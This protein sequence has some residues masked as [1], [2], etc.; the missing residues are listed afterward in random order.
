MNVIPRIGK[1]PE[2]APLDIT[3]EEFELISQTL[4]RQHGFNLDAYKD[5][6]IKRRIAIRVRATRCATVREYCDILLNRQGEVEQLLKVLT[7]HVSQFFRNP[8]T[9]DKLRQEIIPYLFTF[10][11]QEGRRDLKFWSVGCAGGEE[12]YSLA[13]LLKEHFPDELAR[14]AVTIHG[15][16]VDAG[17]LATAPLGVF[18]PERLHDLPDSYRDRYFTTEHGRFHL[19]PE[20][21]EMVTF[22]Q[23]DLQ[24]DGAYPAADLILCR[25]VLIYFER[26][27]QERIIR[28]FARALRAGGILVLGKS[29][30][31]FGESRRY[32]QTLCPVERIYRVA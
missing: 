10:A 22:A 29:E 4:Q 2:F 3:A 31:L 6:C 5:K 27:Q 18:G 8:A 24:H 17:V 30:T 23:G 13:L 21:K 12:P 9:F 15:T 28:G 7:I 20:L 14:F 1:I 11:R 25:N 32:F 26:S 19:G 16:D